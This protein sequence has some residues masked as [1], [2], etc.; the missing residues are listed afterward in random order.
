MNDV[1]VAVGTSKGMWL[2]RSSDRRSWTVDGPHF[3]MHSVAACAIDARGDEVRLLAGAVSSHWGPGV[4]WSDD[5]GATWTESPEGVHF[6]PEVGESVEA[7]W[8][9]RPDTQG[10]PG[11][12]WAGSQPSALWRSDD[13][14]ETFSLVDALWEHP[15]RPQWDAGYGGQAI[16][17]VL[18]HPERDGHVLVA[19]STGG[20]YVTD[21]DGASWAPSNRG[22]DAG[23][24]PGEEPEFGQCVHKVARDAGDPQRLF[25]Q[26]HGG[27]YRSDD[28]GGSW[29]SIA[30]GLPA[31]FGFP[32]VTHPERGGTAWLVPLVADG[33]RVPPDASLRVWR[34]DDSGATWAPSEA[35][36]PDAFYGVVLRDAMTADDADPAGVYLGT[37][38]GS[39]YASADEGE[40]W[41][42]I[43]KHLPDVLCVRAVVL[44]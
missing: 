19:M 1:M 20:V 10:R 11:V 18:P 30:S 31:D 3:F 32:I 22:I 27:V 44:P 25:A 17:T 13:R 16:H 42:E 37:R 29:S 35:G 14:G 23:F 40:T 12:V 24:L 7:V 21:D 33:E 2:L 43:A 28:G 6:A 4:S 5:L 38:D 9:L 36:L 26:N 39:V 41:S 34:T 15:H 8:Q